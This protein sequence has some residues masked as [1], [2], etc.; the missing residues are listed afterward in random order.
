MVIGDVLCGHGSAIGGLLPHG[1]QSLGL[2]HGVE[3]SFSSSWPPQSLGCVL[4]VGLQVSGGAV[5]GHQ[6]VFFTLSV[7]ATL[8]Y[9]RSQT[10]QLSALWPSSHLENEASAIHCG[11]FSSSSGL[12]HTHTQTHVHFNYKHQYKE[13]YMAQ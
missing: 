1:A 5:S 13:K 3:S 7:L 12:T 6:V 11:H 9:R 4:C 8:S 2:G 10:K